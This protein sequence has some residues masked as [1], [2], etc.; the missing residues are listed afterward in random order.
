MY[1]LHTANTLWI[2]LQVFAGIIMSIIDVWSNKYN[3][4]ILEHNLF[5]RLGHRV[6][7]FRQKLAHLCLTLTCRW[8]IIQNSDC[9]HTMSS[10]L[11]VLHEHVEMR[12]EIKWAH[13]YTCS[14]NVASLNCHKIISYYIHKTSRLNMKAFREQNINPDYISNQGQFHLGSVVPF[15]GCPQSPSH[16]PLLSIAS[17]QTLRFQHNLP[18]SSLLAGVL[19]QW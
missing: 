15:I 3:A 13:L 11:L 2:G 10:S 17:W 6:F 14:I 4:S 9:I 8:K 18:S 19:Q 5:A 1:T 12:L 7:E 16:T